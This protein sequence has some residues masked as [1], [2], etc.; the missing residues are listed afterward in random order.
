MEFTDFFCVSEPKR[1]VC[2]PDMFVTKGI[3]LS[4][5]KAG[6]GEEE[7]SPRIGLPAQTPLD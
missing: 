3:D 7:D 2:Y 6:D 5:I 1:T 4:T